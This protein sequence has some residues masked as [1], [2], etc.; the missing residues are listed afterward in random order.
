MARLSNLTIENARIFFKDFSAAGPYAGG[1][2]RTFCV[3]IPEDMVEALEKDGW[4]LKSRESRTDP[5]ALTHYLKVEVSYRA[6]PPKIIC[7][8][9]LTRR[10]VFITEQTV[11]SLDYVEILNVDLTINPYVWEVNGNSGVKAYLG[12][13]YVTIAED[14]LDAKYDDAEEVAA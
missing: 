11:D 4:N 13:M 8:P 5:D 12:T 3:E 1:T 6:R 10:K 9:N 2:K 7:I 14:P